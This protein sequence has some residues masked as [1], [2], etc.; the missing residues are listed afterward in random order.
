VPID[1]TAFFTSSENINVA[2]GVGNADIT[3]PATN[4]TANV[5]GYYSADKS[6]YVNSLDSTGKGLNCPT[7]DKRLNIAGAIVV[8]AALGGGLFTNQRDLCLGNLQCPAFS[9][10][11]RPDFILNTPDFFKTTEGSGRCA[12]V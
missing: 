12:V 1:S 9:I 6:F 8:N 10:I 5:Q 3:L 11:E 7:S 2:S 4:L